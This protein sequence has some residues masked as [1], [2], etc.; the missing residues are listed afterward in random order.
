M[1]I[2]LAAEPERD[3]NRHDAYNLG[4]LYKRQIVER[5]K[6]KTVTFIFIMK[7]TVLDL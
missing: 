5:A 1:Y 7:V 3:I 6:K 2:C 4:T